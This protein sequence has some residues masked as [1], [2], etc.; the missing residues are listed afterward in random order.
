LNIGKPVH[1]VVIFILC[2]APFFFQC[3]AP[4]SI[5]QPFRPFEHQKI[6]SLISMGREQERKVHDLFSSGHLTMIRQGSEAELNFLIAGVRDSG[7]IKIE[8]THPW[9]RPVIHILINKKCFQILSFRERRYYCGELGAIDAMGFLPGRLDPDQ[10]WPLIRAY[11]VIREYHRVIALKDN[12]VAVLDIN[13]EKVQLI[14]FYPQTGLP[15]LMSF[16]RQDVKVSFS[17]FQNVNGIYYARKIGLNDP[18]TDSVV[19]LDL[20]QIVFNKGIPEKLFELA[21]PADFEH[22][23]LQ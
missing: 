7:K 5:K 2:L 1:L 3:C 22:M 8:I 23:L 13:N 15:C 6:D 16:P 12:Q 20:K 11:P 4:T 10:I 9:G 18:K 17:S 21:K 19:T 14:D